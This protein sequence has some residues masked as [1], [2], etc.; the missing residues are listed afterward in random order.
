MPVDFDPVE[1]GIVA[2]ASFAIC[3]LA[4]AYPARAAASLRPVEGLR[5]G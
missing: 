4:T 2:V 1:V 5:H 3:L